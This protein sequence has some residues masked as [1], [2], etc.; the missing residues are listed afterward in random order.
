MGD[1]CMSP[2]AGT[3]FRFATCVRALT[4]IHLPRI[5]ADASTDARN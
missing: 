4:D 3:S 1:N 2:K 5:C